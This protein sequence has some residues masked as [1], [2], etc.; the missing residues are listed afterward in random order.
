M[1]SPKA[2]VLD[3]DGT[4]LLSNDAHASAYADAAATL[5]I[6]ADLPKIRRLI[7][8]GSD[9]LLPEAFD[10]N[11]ES[12]LGSRLNDE[13]GR[14]FRSRYLPT[15]QPAPGAR[16]LL[17]R[18]RR[19]G[20]SLVVATSAGKDDVSPLLQRAGVSDLIKDTVSADDA[21]ASKPDP[22]ILEA[23]LNKVGEDARNAVML[24]DTPY[25]VEAARR[26]GIRIIAV[27]C[28][29]W[30]DQDLA[31]AAAV[32]DSPADVLAHFDQSLFSD[33]SGLRTA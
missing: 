3:I 11:A 7:G 2:V 25:D 10:L 33:E 31:G 27:R 23:A 24:G 16:A 17:L 1:N 13:K 6:P 21:D 15:L 18:L 9:K 19:E 5:G 4:L 8:K 32:Y 26:A 14:I 30:T 12:E 20:V 28:G 29:G 22:D